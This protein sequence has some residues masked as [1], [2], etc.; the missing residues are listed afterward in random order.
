MAKDEKSTPAEPEP[1]SE[2]VKSEAPTN[3]PTGVTVETNGAKTFTQE[4]FNQILAQRL[5]QER[6]KYADYEA[7]KAQNEQLAREREAEKAR[8][9]ELAEQNKTLTA[10]QQ[11][12]ATEAA[13]IRA[14]AK[15]GLDAEAAVKLAEP[16][17]FKLSEGGALENADEIARG[18]A[19]RFPGLTKRPVPPQ[20][21]VNPQ[22]G[23]DNQ[24]RVAP[25]V[26][27]AQRRQRYFGGGGGASGFWNG[28]G[29]RLPTKDE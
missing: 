13:L 12:T 21:A 6:S 19:E 22:D 4:E 15:L 14:A 25:E 7:V 3:P 5:Q 18:I 29:V 23:G 17:Q 24:T 2:P 20:A 26:L 27:D 16:S 28:G 1:Q 9:T 8:V 10:T 11:K